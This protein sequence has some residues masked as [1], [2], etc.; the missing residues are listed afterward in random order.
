MSFLIILFIIIFVLVL[1]DQIKGKAKR[2]ARFDYLMKKYADDQLVQKIFDRKFWH[3]DMFWLVNSIFYNFHY[4][5]F[6]L[7]LFIG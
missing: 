4:F 3:H 1:I 7:F 2:K 6:R 5:S